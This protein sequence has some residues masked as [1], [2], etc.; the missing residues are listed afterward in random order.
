M[1]CTKDFYEGEDLEAILEAIDEKIQHKDDQFRVDVDGLIRE[2]EAEPPK[3][4]VNV[5]NARNIGSLNKV[6]LNI[7]IRNT[8]ISI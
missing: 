8:Q 4:D 1:V 2:L 6:F 5:K 3:A 7:K